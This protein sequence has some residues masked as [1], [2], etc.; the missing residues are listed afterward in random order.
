MSKVWGVVVGGE[1]HCGLQ[2]RIRA[3]GCVGL[4]KGRLPGCGM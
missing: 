4:G 2:Q 3:E 1:G